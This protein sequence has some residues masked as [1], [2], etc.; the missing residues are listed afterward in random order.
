MSTFN[1]GNDLVKV[2]DGLQ[3]A[4]LLRRGGAAS[5]TLDAVLPRAV[6]TGEA[7]ASG[8]TYTASDLVWY[9]AAADL[10]QPP[11]PGEVIVD[12]AGGRWTILQVRRATLQS[13]WR[14]ATRNLAVAHGLD[15]HV[16]IEQATFRKNA[17]GVEEPTWHTWKTGI[18]ARIQPQV[19]RPQSDPQNQTTMLRYTIYLAEEVP[20]DHRCRIRAADGTRYRVIAVRKPQRIDALLEVDAV[21]VR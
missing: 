7:G 19:A 17:A 12:S 15:Q 4:T 21:P 6:R 9:L 13:V 16:D 18:A 20:L 14:C 5:V 2:A 11:Q 10:E 8:G 1:P 3:R